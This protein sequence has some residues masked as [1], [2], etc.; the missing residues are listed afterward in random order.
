M[1][2][3]S[4]SFGAVHTWDIGTVG[5]ARGLYQAEK[6]QYMIMIIAIDDAYTN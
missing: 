3:N 2:G 5:R 1:A 4:D 6:P